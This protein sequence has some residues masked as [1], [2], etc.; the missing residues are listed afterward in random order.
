MDDILRTCIGPALCC[1][2]IALNAL[3]WRELKQL[4]YLKQSKTDYQG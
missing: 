2:V 4:Q 3:I 1:L